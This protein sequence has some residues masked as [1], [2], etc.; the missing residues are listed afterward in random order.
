MLL[1]T[2]KRFK[3]E[4]CQ[5]AF[6]WKCELA[7][8][9]RKHTDKRAKR[10]TCPVQGCK[11]DYSSKHALQRHRRDDHSTGA[12]LI[13]DFIKEDGTVCGKESKTKTLHSQHF[14]H[15]HTKGFQALCGDYFPWPKQR[16]EHQKDCTLCISIKKKKGK[17]VRKSKWTLLWVRSSVLFRWFKFTL[18]P[19]NRITREKLQLA[20][21][22]T[23]F[24]NFLVKF[25]H[26][27]PW[28][29]S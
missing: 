18:K 21:W 25:G 2:G 14:T 3:C 13:C 29:I 20:I 16:S 12:L 6:M 8:H 26:N 28:D 5:K 15:A 27:G 17:M 23:S 4:T 1:H 9:E 7:D 19:P 22:D 11:K 24:W 10:I